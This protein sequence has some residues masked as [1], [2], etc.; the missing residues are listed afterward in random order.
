[1]QYMANRQKEQ[2]HKE[3]ERRRLQE[4]HIMRQLY[5]VYFQSESYFCQMSG[6]ELR[7]KDEVRE[8]LHGVTTTGVI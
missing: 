5:E 6:E 4:Y 2:D 8:R 3:A 1:M 7:S